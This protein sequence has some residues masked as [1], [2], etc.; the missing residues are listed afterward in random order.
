MFSKLTGEPRV[1]RSLACA[2]LAGAA[3]AAPAHAQST[4]DAVGDF[5]PTY[6]GP[7]NGDLDVTSIQATYDG[8]TFRLDA[9]T[10]APIGTTASGIYVWGV[11]RGKGTAGF[12]QI[13]ATNVTFD[14]V[15]IVNPGAGTVTV[16][17]IVNNVTTVLPASAITVSGN[18]I[19]VEIPAHLLTPEGLK[20][21]EFL[22]N[23]WPRNVAGGDETISDFAPDNSDAPLILAFPVPES[24]SVQ[25]EMVFDDA[26]DRFDRIQRRL[27]DQ[28]A[29]IG[30]YGAIGGFI[31]VGARFGDRG[32]GASLARNIT[33]R[34][35]AVGVDYGPVASAAELRHPHR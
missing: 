15:V 12:A 4:S 13:G 16:R 31:D 24:A 6:T 7:L 2:L 33:N 27:S 32:T 25:T 17:D 28:R 18:S 10:A 22:V 1:R 5:L 23:L 14:M 20:Q 8:A 34:V 9:T 3:L 11:E 35:L 30:S 29:G 21:A 26:N 19:S